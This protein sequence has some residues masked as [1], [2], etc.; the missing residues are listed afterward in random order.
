[1][2]DRRE[3]KREVRK[4]MKGQCK[5]GKIRK[6][7]GME[8]REAR[9]EQSGGELQRREYGREGRWRLMERGRG[10]EEQRREKTH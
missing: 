8:G 10:R 9:G 6:N 3:G 7:I 2:G 4:G 1:M 5:G